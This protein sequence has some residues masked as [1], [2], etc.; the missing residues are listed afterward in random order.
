LKSGAIKTLEVVVPVK[1]MRS[2]KDGLDKNMQKALKA[3]ENPNII[4]HLDK[5]EVKDSTTPTQGKMVSASGTL[6]IG[7]VK[8]A[9]ILDG[10]LTED[11]SGAR[12]QGVE[13]LLMTDY[14]IKPPKI[15]VIKTSNEVKVHYDLRLDEKGR[16]K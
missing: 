1:D 16:L 13:D 14:G 7:G 9:V 8:N 2:G 12:I 6:E 15:L 5:Y 10:T 3:E 4:F 11:G